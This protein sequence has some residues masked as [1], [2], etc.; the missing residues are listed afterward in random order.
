MFEWKEDRIETIYLPSKWEYLA[1][2]ISVGRENKDFNELGKLGWQLV[3]INDDRAYFKRPLAE[4]ND[5]P[6]DD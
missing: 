6:T 3:T 1:T 2:W 5:T 4:E